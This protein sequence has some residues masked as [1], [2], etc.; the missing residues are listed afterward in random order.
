MSKEF[1]YQEIEDGFDPRIH[2]RILIDFIREHKIKKIAEV[3]VYECQLAKEILRTCHEEID[4]YWGIDKWD[5]FFPEG[6]Y[7]FKNNKKVVWDSRYWGTC[8]YMPFFLKFRTLRM[9]SEDAAKIFN[10]WSKY[11]KVSEYFDLVYIDA[12]HTYPMVK[13]DIE[14]WYPLVKKGG[15]IG[16]HDYGF[17]DLVCNFGGVKRAVDE[18]FGEDNEEVKVN[19]HS[20]VWYVRK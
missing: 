9:G 17:P 7:T 10:N 18:I 3:G 13:K 5:E 20:G 15:F 19:L 11:T 12:D 1:K 8:K 6:S 2:N 14:L 16:G 4:E